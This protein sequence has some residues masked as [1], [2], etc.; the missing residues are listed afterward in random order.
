M[1]NVPSLVPCLSGILYHHERWDGTG[2]PE[3][4]KGKNIPIEAR[5]LAIAD[6]FSAMTSARPYRDAL[7]AEKVLKE[8]ERGAGTQ[9]DPELVEVFIGIIEAGFP[10]KVKAGSELSGEQS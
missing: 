5:I 2:Y 10:E 3:G 1:G 7:C 6:A 9:F 4:L 8:F